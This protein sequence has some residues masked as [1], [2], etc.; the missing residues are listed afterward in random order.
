MRKFHT[1]LLALAIP[2]VL[3]VAVVTA[4][5]GDTDSPSSAPVDAPTTKKARPPTSAATG[6]TQPS[7]T[8]SRTTPI[9]TA[10]TLSAAKRT[11]LKRTA[12]KTVELTRIAR[13]LNTAR[14]IH[15]APRSSSTRAATSRD[16]AMPSRGSPTRSTTRPFPNRLTTTTTMEPLGPRLVTGPAMHRAG[17]TAEARRRAPG[18]RRHG[19]AT[20]ASTVPLPLGSEGVIFVAAL[21][22]PRSHSHRRSRQRQREQQLETAKDSLPRTSLHVDTAAHLG[23]ERRCRTLGGATSPGGVVQRTLR[24]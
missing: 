5:D 24:G 9:P 4:C 18:D 6:S 16:A 2:V 3:A 1:I 19:E 21:T 23:Q 12:L 10:P 15:A 22:E 11:R 20:A 17:A 7:G 8:E 14:V 13:R